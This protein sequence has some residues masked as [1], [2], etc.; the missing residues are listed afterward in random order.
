[1]ENPTVADPEGDVVRGFA[2]VGD[3]VAGKRFEDLTTGF[4]LLVRVARDET[5]EPPVGHVDEAGAVDPAVG[6]PA[7]K[8]GSAEVRPRDL[9]R[10]SRAIRRDRPLA[11]LERLRPDPAGVVVDGD[12]GCPLPTL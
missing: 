11:L 8:V 6:H 2:A 5:P 10:R 7:P 1:M 3:E 9:D 12:D 4:L